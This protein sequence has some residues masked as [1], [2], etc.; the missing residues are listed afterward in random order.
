MLVFTTV[1]L[2]SARARALR[3]AGI[4]IVQVPSRG[5]HVD[6]KPALRELGRR[7]ILSVLLEAGSKLN[8]AALEAGIVDKMI[9]F[10]APRIFGGGVPFV[11]GRNRHMAAI[12]PLRNILLDRIGPDFVVEGYLRD[13]YR[14]R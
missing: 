11:R 3:R 12:P 7:Q 8:G 6:L 1:P 9:L 5:Q 10:F 13:V 14:N 4:E 2:D